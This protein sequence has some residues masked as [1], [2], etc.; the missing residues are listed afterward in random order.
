MGV[1]IHACSQFLRTADGAAG[2]ARP[3][4]SGPPDLLGFPVTEQEPGCRP[5]GPIAWSIV[6]PFKGGAEAKSRLGRGVQGYVGVAPGARGRIAQAFLEDTLAAVAAVPG[7]QRIVLVTPERPRLGGRCDVYVP[8]PGRGLNAAVAAGIER[9]RSVDPC[10][11]VAA[12]AADL[13]CLVPDDLADALELAGHSASCVVADHV[14]SGST[15]IT[16]LPGT[17]LVPRFGP[18][19]WR[20]H[21]TSG[22]RSLPLPPTSTLRMDVDTL[23]DLGRAMR[24]GAG[25]STR[26]ALAQERIG[27][28]PDL[29]L[30]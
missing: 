12:L 21:V 23:D 16:A 6:I 11:G 1:E 8:D 27:C 24:H 5:L 4:V 13:P 29:A 14:G 2:P 7:V 15:M 22:H 10:T 9:A 28:L 30:S 3:G 19:S 26:A 18:L 20:A 25:P 17:A